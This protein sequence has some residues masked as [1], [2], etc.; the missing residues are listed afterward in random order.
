[1]VKN[2]LLAM[3]VLIAVTQESFGEMVFSNGITDSAPN[4]FN[5][6]T[7]GQAVDTNL[8]ASGIGRGVGISGNAGANRYNATGFATTLADSITGNDYFTFTLTSHTGFQLNLTS[9]AYTGQ[10]SATGPVAF[11]FRS[12]IDSFANTIGSAT[13]VGTTISLSDPSFQGLKSATEFRFYAGGGTGGTYS[14]NEFGFSGSVTAVPE[15]TS[16]AL[17]SL[18]CCTGFVAAFRR[19]IAKSKIA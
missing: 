4:L 15:P 7:I 1:M 5:P 19:R 17:V 10:A 12:S 6:F 13:V 2:V 3:V 8:T 11:S 16:I 14:I 18:M 9:F